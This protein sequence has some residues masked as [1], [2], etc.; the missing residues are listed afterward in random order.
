MLFR[1][2]DAEWRIVR[3]RDPDNPAAEP[4][5]NAPRFFAAFGRDVEVGEGQLSYDGITRHLTYAEGNRRE[6]RT[7]E[8][9]QAVLEFV[10]GTPGKSGRAIEAAIT[11]DGAIT[12]AAVR[13]ALAA[14][15]A[16]GLLSIIIGSHRAKLHHITNPG[17]VRLRALHGEIDDWPEEPEPDPSEEFVSP[18]QLTA[19]P[20]CFAPHTGPR[21]TL[22]QRCEKDK[23]GGA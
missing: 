4:A 19:C 12:Q 3:Q 5:P 21:G 15:T 13:E 2:P 14:A 6:T 18:P 8:A 7:R 11:S 10:A 22:C 23:E 17:R 16:T 1:S 9:Q 20:S